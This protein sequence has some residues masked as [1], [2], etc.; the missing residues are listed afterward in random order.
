MIA[1]RL[2]QVATGT[3]GEAA[4][5]AIFWLKCRAGWSAPREDA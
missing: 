3:S 2:F 4:R 5:A 1:E